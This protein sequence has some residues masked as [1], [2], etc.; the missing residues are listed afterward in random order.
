MALSAYWGEL[1][2][3]AVGGPSAPGV[4]QAAATSKQEMPAIFF[5]TFLLSKY[6]Y[7]IG[8]EIPQDERLTR[9]L[10]WRRLFCELFSREVTMNR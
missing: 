10:G 6:E 1:S 7:A 8:P 5:M 2:R 3:N 9:L 4:A